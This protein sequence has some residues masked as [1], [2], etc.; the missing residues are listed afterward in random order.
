MIS[1]GPRGTAEPCADAKDDSA[2]ALEE[3]SPRRTQGRT[4]RAITRQFPA[5]RSAAVFRTGVEGSAAY[6]YGLRIGPRLRSIM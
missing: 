2:M 4:T 3:S 6:R 1:P 5:T